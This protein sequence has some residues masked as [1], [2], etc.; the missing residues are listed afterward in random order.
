[1]NVLRLA[2]IAPL[3]P[4]NAFPVRLSHWPEPCV[5]A[6]ESLLSPAW[7]LHLLNRV[8]ANPQKHTPPPDM[9]LIF[10]LYRQHPARTLWFSL[11]LRA[12]RF[13]GLAASCGWDAI[14]SV[15]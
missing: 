10:V 4:W 1:M 11:L 12:H 2:P 9:H 13:P 8:K 3:P 5:Y 15:L 7:E 6:L 14:Q